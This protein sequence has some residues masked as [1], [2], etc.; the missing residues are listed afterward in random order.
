MRSDLPTP[1]WY[2]V[3]CSDRCSCLICSNALL[4]PHTHTLSTLVTPSSHSSHSLPSCTLSSTCDDMLLGCILQELKCAICLDI[5]ED[6][7]AIPCQV[8]ITY[9]VHRLYYYLPRDIIY[10]ILHGLLTRTTFWQHHFCFDC[11]SQWFG[12]K[13]GKNTCPL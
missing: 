8:H 9:L 3:V 4:S 12:E 1:L 6:P 11:I 10:Y 2:A 5:M 13:G 7:A